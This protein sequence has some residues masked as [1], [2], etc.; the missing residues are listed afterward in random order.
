MRKS[1]QGR[2][3]KP[4]KEKHR[5]EKIRVIYCLTTGTPL[6]LTNWNES[7]PQHWSTRMNDGPRTDQPE[8]MVAPA[9]ISQNKCWPY[10]RSRVLRAL[11]VSP[12][13]TGLWRPEEKSGWLLWWLKEFGGTIRDVTIYQLEQEC[14]NILK[15]CTII[16]MQFSWMPALRKYVGSVSGRVSCLMCLGHWLAWCVA[17]VLDYC[18][19]S[20]KL[21]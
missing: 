8:W 16:R 15:I 2:G 20:M 13:I 11:A 1:I 7:W 17:V 4:W 12:L 6:G 21:I 3:N 19:S 9:L 5:R 18:Y 14:F 10:C